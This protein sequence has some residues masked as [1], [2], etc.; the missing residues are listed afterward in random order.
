MHHS[1]TRVLTGLCAVALG[2]GMLGAAAPAHANEAPPPTSDRIV[3]ISAAVPA[4]SSPR[5]NTAVATE[6][7]AGDRVPAFCGFTNAGLEWVKVFAGDTFGY[8]QS[9]SVAGGVGTLP[10][11]CPS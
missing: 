5:L 4:Y 11:D 6:L 7:H 3:S 9:A 10:R 8:V 2:A 1:T